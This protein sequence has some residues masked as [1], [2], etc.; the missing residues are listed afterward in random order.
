MYQNKFAKKR[1]YKQ[2]DKIITH[3]YQVVLMFPIILKKHCIS[4]VYLRERNYSRT[5]NVNYI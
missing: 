5:Q 2:K 1:F 3:N 4:H